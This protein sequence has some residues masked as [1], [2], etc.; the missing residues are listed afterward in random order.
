MHSVKF[1]V[2]KVDQSKNEVEFNVTDDGG[3]KRLTLK[4]P[5][6][7]VTAINGRPNKIYTLDLPT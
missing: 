2:I 6:N 1:T 7:V 5:A 4:L 3:S